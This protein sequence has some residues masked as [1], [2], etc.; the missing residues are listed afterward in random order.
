M[1]DVYHQESVRLTATAADCVEAA[2]Q[3]L[4][5]I[6]GA[7]WVDSQR[8]SANLGSWLKTRGPQLMFCPLSW[9]P[10]QVIVNVLEAGG[11]RQIVVNV[12]DRL[13]I[14]PIILGRGRYTKR[15]Y[16]VAVAVRDDISGRLTAGH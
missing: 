3:A 4:V 9:L 10:I 15:C 13:P 12:G 14:A 5:Q 7:P 6:G 16:Q 11:Q 8:V 1:P 2:R